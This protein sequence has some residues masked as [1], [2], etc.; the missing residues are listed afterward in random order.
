[1]EKLSRNNIQLYGEL[2]AHIPSLKPLHAEILELE[3]E[4]DFIDLQKKLID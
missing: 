4:E 1:M 3:P 2:Q